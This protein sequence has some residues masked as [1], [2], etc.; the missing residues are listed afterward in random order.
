MF[1]STICAVNELRADALL[2]A[3]L[4]SAQTFFF[5][6]LQVVVPGLAVCVRDFTMFVIRTHGY[7]SYKKKKLFCF[8]N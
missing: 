2:V 8:I 4:I 7:K 3:G 5:Y 1:E 6:D